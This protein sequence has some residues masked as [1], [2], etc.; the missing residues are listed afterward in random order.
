[1]KRN[2]SFTYLNVF[3]EVLM[4]SCDDIWIFNTVYDLLEYTYLEYHVTIYLILDDHTFLFTLA[5]IFYEQCILNL[6]LKYDKNYQS[7]KNY[8]I[9][10]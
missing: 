8:F 9:D 4:Y 2:D 10:N 3:V 5:I 7:L 1:M 6:L